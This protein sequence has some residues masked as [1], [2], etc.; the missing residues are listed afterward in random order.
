VAFRWTRSERLIS[1]EAGALLARLER[2]PSPAN[3]EALE[4]WRNADPR[5]AAM[6]RVSQSVLRHSPMLG[7]SDM[8]AASEVSTRSEPT[9]YHPR[10]SQA[11]SITAV[12]LVAA[13]AYLFIASNPFTQGIEAVRL[14]T[15]VGEIRRFALRDGSKITL[16]TAS[17]IRIEIGRTRRAALLERGRARLQIVRGDIPFAVEMAGAS[18]SLDQGVV[19]VSSVDP[20]TPITLIEG[21]ARPGGARRGESPTPLIRAPSSIDR[22]NHWSRTQ[23]TRS[24]ADWTQGHLSFDH[25]KLVDVIAAANRYS[26]KKIL[27]SDPSIAGLRVTGVFRAGDTAALA[28]S[29][30]TAFH[31]EIESDGKGNMKLKR[32]G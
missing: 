16:D 6:L 13:A 8:A 12:A 23:A 5:H 19:E 7:G 20:E 14:A 2:D 15:R 31:L 17:A 21:V 24:A 4:R 27:V 32:T 25:E 9:A 11:A 28:R 29:I 1:R 10:F 18:M 22:S 3:R 26:A 30:A